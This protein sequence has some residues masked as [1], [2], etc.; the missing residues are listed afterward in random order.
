MIKIDLGF[1]PKNL[2]NLC[3]FRIFLEAGVTFNAINRFG[4]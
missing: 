2:C 1:D 3:G 4:F